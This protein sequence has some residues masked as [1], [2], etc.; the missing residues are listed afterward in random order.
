[1]RNVISIAILLF[2]ISSSAA[3]KTAKGLPFINDDFEKA[4]GAAK[5]RNAPL[6][7]EVWAPW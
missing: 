5:Q 6:F 4:L 2:M 7:V 3:G 1:M